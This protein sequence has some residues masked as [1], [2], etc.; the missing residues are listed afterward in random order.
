MTDDATLMKSGP[1]SHPSEDS[2]LQ[3]F[4]RHVQ[5]LMAGCVADTSLGFLATD[6]K[7]VF[8]GG[9]MLRSRLAWRLRQAADNSIETLA[10]A[11]AAVELIH[12]AS[13]LHDDVIDGGVIRR[14]LPTFWKERGVA[15]A[16]LLGDL[17]LFKGIDLICRVEGG[18]LTHDLVKL[19]GEVCEAESEQELLLAGHP[20]RLETCIRIARRKTG[21]LFAFVALAAGGRDP[22]LQAKLKECG[23][24]LGTAYQ[25]ADDLLDA[26]GD[27]VAAGKT[28]RSDLRRDIVSAAA[29]DASCDTHPLAYIEQTQLRCEAALKNHEGAVA[30][31]R[32]YVEHDLAPAL[33]QLLEGCKAEGALT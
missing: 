27:E 9:K 2:D 11:A 25:L 14:G 15:G 6:C 24:Q 26:T 3:S 13:I 1:A 16:I 10:H 12:S 31:V 22:S 17:L 5:S 18:R 8:S 30:G 23:Y 33:R 20:S 7:N 19:T 29:V 32:A 21:A 28:L 4:L